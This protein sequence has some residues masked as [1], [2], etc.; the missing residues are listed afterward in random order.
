MV[1]WRRRRRYTIGVFRLLALS[2]LLI[3]M[4]WHP[5]TMTP[6]SAHLMVDPLFFGALGLLVSYLMRPTRRNPLNYL[7]DAQDVEAI[8]PLAESMQMALPE[9]SMKAIPALLRLLSRVNEQNAP[10][11]TLYQRTCLHKILGSFPQEL[12]G[13][14]SIAGAVSDVVGTPMTLVKTVRT[15]ANAQS[16][17]GKSPTRRGHSVRVYLH[18]QQRLPARGA[19]PCPPRRQSPDADTLFPANLQ[20]AAQEV[21][22]LLA[23]RVKQSDARDVSLRPATAPFDTSTLLHPA[24][25]VPSQPAGESLRVDAHSQADVTQEADVSYSSYTNDVPHP[26]YTN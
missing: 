16:R 25:G 15:L 24:Q 1:K 17:S 18:G 23:E 13:L 20:K 19:A 21:L 4:F 22:P 26:S 9:I 3:F 8:G 11:L 7:W 2:P 5:A 10:H 6:L 14:A 12:D